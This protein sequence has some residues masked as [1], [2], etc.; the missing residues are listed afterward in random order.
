MSTNVE[1]LKERYGRVPLSSFLPQN[2][3]INRIYI[4]ATHDYRK[5][6]SDHE[7]G[8]KPYNLMVV[9]GK[10]T[11]E[12]GFDMAQFLESELIKFVIAEPDREIW[13]ENLESPAWRREAERV[14]MPVAQFGNR[15]TLA[16]GLKP[17]KSQ[18]YVYVLI[19][20]KR[21]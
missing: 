12:K 21:L 4:G 19:G 2:I 6:K 14:G 16:N 8:N 13:Y 3:R 17:D 1:D 5:R 9:L 7:Q 15:T 10:I 18:Y 11:G 20:Y